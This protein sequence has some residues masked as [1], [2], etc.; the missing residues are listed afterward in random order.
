MP[1]LVVADPKGKI[2]DHP[3]LEMVG[4]LGTDVVGVPPEDLLRI[5]EGSRLF[6]MPGSLPLAWDRRRREFRPVTR[7]RIGGRSF[8]STTVAA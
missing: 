2:L 6:T 3:S 1:N 8:A 4:R 7:V 5:P